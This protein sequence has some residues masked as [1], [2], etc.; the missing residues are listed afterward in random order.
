MWKDTPDQ[1]THEWGLKVN[2][3]QSPCVSGVAEGSMGR[4][5]GDKAG[6]EANI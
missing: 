4:G 1:K 2:M 5:H 3:A 6:K